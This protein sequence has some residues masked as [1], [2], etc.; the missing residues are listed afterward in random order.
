[1]EIGCL[2]APSRT[3]LGPPVYGYAPMPTILVTSYA[4]IT[5]LPVVYLA[6]EVK[7]ALMIRVNATL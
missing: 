2:M 5:L 7:V 4:K 3:T 6:K 1:M